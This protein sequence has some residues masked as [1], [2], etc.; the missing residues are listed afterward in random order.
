MLDRPAWFNACI[1]GAVFATI[2][3]PASAS[4]GFFSF[5]L[6]L[7]AVAMFVVPMVAAVRDGELEGK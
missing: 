2:L 6:N 7:A 4:I 5:L 3:I 1:I